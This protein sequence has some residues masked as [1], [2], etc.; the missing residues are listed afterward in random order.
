MSSVIHTKLT[1]DASSSLPALR[2]TA[3]TSEGAGSFGFEGRAVSSFCIGVGVLKK[4]DTNFEA[5]AR[6]SSILAPKPLVSL[7]AS[8]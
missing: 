6:S 8:D 1:I 2:Q 4:A 7:A 5:I 3:H